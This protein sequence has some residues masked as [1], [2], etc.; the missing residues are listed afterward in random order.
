MTVLGISTSYFIQHLVDSVLVHNERRLLNALGIGMVLIIL[1]RTVFGVL[2]EYLVAHVGRKV[3]LALVAGYTRHLQG[4]PLQFFETRQVG[5]VL[6]RINDAYKVREAVSGA[7]LTTVVDGTLVS[8][9][10]AVL[11]ACDARLALVATAFLPVLVVSAAPRGQTEFQ[12]NLKLG[13]TPCPPDPM[14]PDPM[15]PSEGGRA[16]P[17][18]VRIELRGETVGRGPWH[19]RVRLGMAGQ[20]EIVTG[21]ESLLSLLRKSFSQ[22]ISLNQ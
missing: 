14:P 4:L 3:D 15:P 12:V 19:G 9:L 21:R 8:V 11:W 1:F 16:A 10:L 6:S 17:F 5:E 20:A 18:T 22:S 13:L 7:T 2:R